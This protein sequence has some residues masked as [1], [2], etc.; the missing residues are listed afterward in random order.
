M[1]DARK[2]VVVMVEELVSNSCHDDTL[3]TSAKDA[4]LQKARNKCIDM[5]GKTKEEAHQVAAR[6]VFRNVEQSKGYLGFLYKPSTFYYS[7]HKLVISNWVDVTSLQ[8]LCWTGLKCACCLQLSS[9][10][11]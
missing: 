10:D 6:L 2:A 11:S 4:L 5:S 3:T 8:I 1:S 7:H 9:E